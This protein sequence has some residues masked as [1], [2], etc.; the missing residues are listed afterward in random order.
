MLLNQLAASL[1]LVGV[2]SA[3][4]SSQPQ[5]KRR[6]HARAASLA[7]RG[8]KDKHSTSA[9]EAAAPAADTAT[10]DTLHVQRLI[11]E[12]DVATDVMIQGHWVVET[13]VTSN[14]VRE[15]ISNVRE[16]I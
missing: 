1:V 6:H 5:L 16:W 8:C 14:F 15:S 13:I 12:H 10:P 9:A 3:H 2:V 4:T 7:N 11:A